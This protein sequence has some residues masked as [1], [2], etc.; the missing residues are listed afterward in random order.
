MQSILFTNPAGD[1]LAIS[2][3]APYFLQGLIGMSD[4]P[5]DNLSARGYAQDGQSAAGQY[6]Q[7]RPVS[8]AVIV[9]GNNMLDA[10]QNRRRLIA[11]LNPKDGPYQAVYQN[12]YMRVTFSCRVSDPPSF[13][14]A[15]A[16]Q[17][18]WK[19]CAVSLLADDPYLYDTGETAVVLSIAEPKLLLPMTFLTGGITLSTM[20]NKRATIENQGDVST[21]VRIRFEGG[22]TNPVITNASTDEFIRV[23]KAIA[24]TEVLEITTGYG[25]KRVEIIQPD[26]SRANAFNYIDLNSTFFE[27]QVGENELVY[28]ASSGADSAAVSIFYRQRYVGV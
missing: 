7:A 16:K 15:Q 8:F 13:E 23:V 6:L 9:G 1:T 25:D 10:Y 22:S 18:V 26:G 24:A 17:S 27:L 28:D 12:D 5:V 20:S 21:P 14:S 11:F 2:Y 19:S 3:S 4:A